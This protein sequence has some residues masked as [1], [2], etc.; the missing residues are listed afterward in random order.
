M[1]GSFPYHAPEAL[2]GLPHTERIDCWASGMVLAEL[3]CGSELIDGATGRAAA[4]E[5]LLVVRERVLR[6]A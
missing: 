1:V 4:L 5:K 6:C 3:T 2:L